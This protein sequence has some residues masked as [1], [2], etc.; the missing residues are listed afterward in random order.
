MSNPA[1]TPNRTIVLY[2][3]LFGNTERIAKAIARGIQR[4]SEVDCL[5]IKNADP[6]TL[7]QYSLVA[8]GAPTQAFSA[9][10]PMKEFLAKLEGKNLAGRYGFAFDTKLDS[11]LSGS[12]AKYIEGKLHDIGLEIIRPRASAIVKGG[13]N[14]AV[15]RAGEEEVFESLGDE[16][17]ATLKK[18]QPQSTV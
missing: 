5:N 16:I 9:S 18:K 3:T 11:R 8:V 4:H 14:D 15:L 13:T 7:S 17:G 2:D 12:A 6:D 10:K 1:L